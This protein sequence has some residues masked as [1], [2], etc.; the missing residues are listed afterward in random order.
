[1]RSDLLENIDMTSHAQITKIPNDIN[2]PANTD[3][4]H[5]FGFLNIMLKMWMFEEEVRTSLI[6]LILFQVIFWLCMFGTLNAIPKPEISKL[7]SSKVAK[8]QLD[9][10]GSPA[11]DPQ[12]DT[13]GAPQSAPCDLEV[14]IGR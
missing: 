14:R 3:N 4:H 1:M 13:Y 5:E 9:T 11:A 12:V 2:V 6:I 10:Y 7:S 8:R